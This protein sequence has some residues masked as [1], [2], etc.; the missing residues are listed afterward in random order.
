MVVVKSVKVTPRE[1]GT[2][3]S[4]AVVTVA[5]GD[6]VTSG[7]LGLAY[8]SVVKAVTPTVAGHVLGGA[9]VTNPGSVNNDV[10]LTLYSLTANADSLVAA[11]SADWVI[12]AEQI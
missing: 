9:A 11:G 7:D 5:N 10:T 12:V 8:I 4:V 3:E 1:D 2:I 6:K